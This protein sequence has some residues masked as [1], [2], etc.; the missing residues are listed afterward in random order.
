MPLQINRAPANDIRAEYLKDYA[1]HSP[2]SA[3]H[4]SANTATL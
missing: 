4:N 2:S 3:H 1:Q